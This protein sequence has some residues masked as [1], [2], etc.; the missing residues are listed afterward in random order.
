MSGAVAAQVL[1]ERFD[2]VRQAEWSRLERKVARLDPALR[3]EV[4]ALIAEVIQGLAD[5]PA[6]QLERADEP[7]LADAALRLFGVEGSIA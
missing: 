2:A 5:L 6:R 7:A 4:E 3:S 1:H